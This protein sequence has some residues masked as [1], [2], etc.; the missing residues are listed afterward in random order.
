LER[1][2]AATQLTDKEIHKAFEL[3]GFIQANAREG[4]D[5]VTL[6]L[7]AAWRGG[8]VWTK[9]DF[10]ESLGKSERIGIKV[11]IGEKS[12]LV[13]YYKPKSP[14][15]DRCFLFVETEKGR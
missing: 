7:P 2:F 3:A 8:A 9:Q 5:K 13:N 14:K 1:W 10:E 6:Q 15:Q 4:R 12:K 11:V